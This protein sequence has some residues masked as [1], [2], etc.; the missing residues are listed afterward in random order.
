VLGDYRRV[1]RETCTSLPGVEVD[2][3][4]D[5]FF[6]AFARAPDALEAAGLITKRLR[7]GPIRRQMG[8]H[9]GSP[10][11]TDE[12]WQSRLSSAAVRRA[13]TTGVPGE[14]P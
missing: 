12:G 7:H 8:V 10:L 13:G 3:Q 11:V 4:G 1:V 5:A 2:T 6:L 14:E 9:T